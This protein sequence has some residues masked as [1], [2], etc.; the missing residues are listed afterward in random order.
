MVAKTW[1]CT[2]DWGEPIAILPQS[3]Q[4]MPSCLLPEPIL[5]EVISDL[6]KAC[7]KLFPTALEIWE[8]YAAIMQTN[9][10][11]IEHGNTEP[12][13][14]DFDWIKRIKPAALPVQVENPLIER[15]QAQMAVRHSITATTSTKKHALLSLGGC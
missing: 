2:K 11:V 4:G 1:H 3:P 6:E 13:P 15:V 9:Q 10:A 7:T 14:A 8:S 5:P 12:D